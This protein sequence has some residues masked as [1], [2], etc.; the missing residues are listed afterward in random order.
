[1]DLARFVQFAVAERFIAETQRQAGPSTGKFASRRG[2]IIQA[3]GLRPRSSRTKSGIESVG[4]AA[5]QA[6][7]KV[8]ELQIPRSSLPRKRGYGRLGMTRIKDLAARLKR[9]RKKSFP[10]TYRA[11]SS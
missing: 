4:E 1:M 3:L 5:K 9:L 7:E 10:G 2:Q 8:H 6:A 11:L